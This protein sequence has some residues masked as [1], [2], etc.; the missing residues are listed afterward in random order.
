MRD[1]TRV[2]SFMG[3]VLAISVISISFL[4]SIFG[5]VNFPKPFM[6]VVPEVFEED[7]NASLA[8]GMSTVQEEDSMMNSSI[9]N[10]NSINTLSTSDKSDTKRRD[11]R[12][13]GD[14]EY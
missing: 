11:S 4:C 2:S 14:G 6:A 9:S 5:E 1:K 7:I 10:Y 13:G 8:G 3:I 12:F